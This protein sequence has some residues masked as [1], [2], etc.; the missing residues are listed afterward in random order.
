MSS[1]VQFEPEDA[2]ALT[3]QNLVPVPGSS[4]A[5]EVRP[6]NIDTLIRISGRDEPTGDRDVS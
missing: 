6:E 5:V 2:V 4:Q 3:W 1:G